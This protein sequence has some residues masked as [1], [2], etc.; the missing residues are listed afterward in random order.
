[1]FVLTTQI[2]FLQREKQILTLRKQNHLNV[3]FDVSVMLKINYL[4]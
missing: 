4:P 3:A 1:M 2:Y